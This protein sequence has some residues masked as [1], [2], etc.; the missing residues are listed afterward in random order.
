VRLTKDEILLVVAVLLIL[1]LGAAVRNYRQH[2]PA[3]QAAPSAV[4]AR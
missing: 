1:V 4:P 3:G 2:H